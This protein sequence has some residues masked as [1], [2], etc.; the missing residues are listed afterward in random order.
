MPT[1]D[2]PTA[3]G[4][5]QAAARDSTLAAAPAALLDGAFDGRK[6]FQQLVRDA[7]AAAAREGWREIILCDASFEDWPLG[8]RAVVESLTAWSKTGRH[9]TLLAKR[10]DTLQTT[11]HR[12]VTWRGRWSHIIDARAVPSADA[13]VFP[14]AI[15]TPAW[16]MR[17]LDPVRSKGVAGVDAHRRV[18]LREEINDWLTKSS[19]AFAAT[20]LGL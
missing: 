4:M 20:T 6:A 10:F 14:S 1:D 15:Y 12:F 7:L 18:L 9:L 16:V 5:T 19:V 13:Q 17:R 2:L 11:Q 3:S 8:E